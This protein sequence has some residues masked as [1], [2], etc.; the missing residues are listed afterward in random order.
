MP[1]SNEK[2]YQLCR[3]YGRKTLFWRQKF[4]GF[5][6]EVNRRRLYEQKGFGS[7]FEFA[8]KLAGLSEEQVRLTLNLERRFED[9][10]TLRAAL[11][12]G[13]VSINKLA[14]V[15]SMATTDNEA[16][17]TDQLKKLPKA[18]VEVFV[19]DFKIQNG[20]QKPKNE[21]KSLPGQ[22]VGLSAEV[23]ERLREL[24]NKGIDTNALILEMLEKREAK[25]ADEEAAIVEAL[26]KTPQTRHVP[27]RTKRF[28]GETYGIKCG[29]QSCSYPA[30]DIHHT[31]PFALNPKHDPRFMVPL[32][33]EHHTITHAINERVCRERAA[34]VSQPMC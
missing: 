10:P 19:R 4:I 12:N 27:A 8:K 25:L 13:E 31:I 20:L 18:A 33:H 2:L 6:P 3:E 28:L 7:I 16:A 11:V 29:L 15:V 1:L 26:P 34:A 9:K 17:L 5:L 24:H 32:C 21:A 30:D 14:R 23:E 22:A